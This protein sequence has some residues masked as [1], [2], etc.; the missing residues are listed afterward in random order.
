MTQGEIYWAEFADAGRRPV[1]V[2]GR[3][4]LN[5][6]H[7][8][9]IVPLTSRQVERRSQL[10]NCV[11]FSAGDFGLNKDCVAQCE[12]LSIVPLE[13]VEL[14]LGPLGRLDDRRLRDIIRAIGHVLDADCEPA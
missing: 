9:L 12:L 3:N 10:P 7:Q 4:E 13:K 1:I 6:G 5:R 8:C 14:H 2:V 11:P